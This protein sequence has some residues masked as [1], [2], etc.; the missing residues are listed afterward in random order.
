MTTTID[1]AQLNDKY[2]ALNPLQRISALYSDF[3]KVL[4]TSSFGT[5]SIILLNMIAS[6]N[7]NQK[8]YFLNTTYHFPETLAYKQEITSKL[9]LQVVDLKPEYWNNQFTRQYEI[10]KTDPDL[11]CSINKTEPLNRVKAEHDVWIS[12]IMGWQS[13][14]RSKRNIFEEKDGIIKFHPLIDVDEAYIKAYMA[15]NG[16]ITHPLTNKGF[17]SVGC[18]H[19]TS[20]G[21]RREGRWE[22]TLKTECGLHA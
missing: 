21:Q 11:C 16:L 13:N 9:G 2:T 7:K 10:Y 20:K 8:V 22:G 6:V 3:D 4:F 1:I 12:G 15:E 17:A 18:I 5:T 19:C 14:S